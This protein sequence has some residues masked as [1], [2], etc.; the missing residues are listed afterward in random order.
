MRRLRA[1]AL[2]LSLVAPIMAPG[3]VTAAPDDSLPAVQVRIALD[4]V[5]AEHA[6]L[7]I[8]AMLT[9]P[10]GGVEHEVAASVLVD[11]TEELVA[12]VNAAYGA[13]AADAFDEQWRNHIAFLLDYTRAVADGDDDARDLAANQLQVY[14]EDFSELLATANPDLPPDVIEGLIAEH[15]QQLQQIASLS[16]A[17]FAELYPAMRETYAHMFMVGDG[18]ALGIVS[19]FGETFTG[20]ETAFSPAIDLRITLD[21]LFGEHVYLAAIAM[22]ARLG[23]S[24]NLPAAADA[25]AANSAELAATIGEIY[26]EDAE[27][28]F[29]DL[30]NNHTGL[31]LDYVA[32]VADD[33]ESAQET[34][35]AGLRQYRSDF[36][37]F[38]V[39]ANPLLDAT[40]LESLLAMH[41]EQ[42][43]EQVDE[44]DGGDDAAAYET[45]RQAYEHSGELSAGLAG[46]IADQ[47]PQQFPDA[48]L[49]V[50]Q[51][52]P[53]SLVIGW[54]LL[55][56][57]HCRDASTMD[58]V[59]QRDSTDAY[60]LTLGEEPR[61]CPA[62]GRPVEPRVLEEDHRPRLV[63]AEGPRH[64][65]KP[66]RRGRHA[67]DRRGSGL[68]RASGDRA[69]PWPMGQSQRIP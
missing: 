68:S 66:A 39:G 18:L 63:C 4:R 34:S 62:C 60:P 11:N 33:D 8:D 49:G 44:Y 1:L 30:W 31:Y 65:A 29:A 67:A 59:A 54:V 17:D 24:G 48:A 6:F 55:A 26:G 20:R 19:R 25:L 56:A 57:G 21:R 15:V 3:A 64:L 13:D 16:Q 5:L 12:L 38:L 28:A 50:S 53:W 37:A 27:A 35:L 69:G 45:L 9:A 40:E 32:G 52:M 10:D 7:I 43:I 58:G 22:R 46:A 47:F 61:F 2:V 23:A 51:P 14:V 41:T 42:L 36:S